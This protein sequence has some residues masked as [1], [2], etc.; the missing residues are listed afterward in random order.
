MHIAQAVV[1]VKRRT[2][3]CSQYFI[4]Y[5]YVIG[6]HFVLQNFQNVFLNMKLPGAAF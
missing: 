5:E 1:S 3:R 6:H 2:V 4:S